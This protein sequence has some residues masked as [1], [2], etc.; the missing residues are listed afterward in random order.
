MKPSELAEMFCMETN[1]PVRHADAPLWM[2]QHMERLEREAFEAGW[3]ANHRPGQAYTP[4][5]M[6]AAYDDWRGS[7]E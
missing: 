2:E 3:V 6:V 1:H 4:E 5:P 7:D